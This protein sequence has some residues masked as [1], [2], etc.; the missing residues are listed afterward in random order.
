MNWGPGRDSTDRETA[1]VAE[2]HIE[3][4]ILTLDHGANESP[5]AC[6]L[7][8]ELVSLGAGIVDLAAGITIIIA[9]LDNL[10]HRLW[11]SKLTLWV[12]VLFLLRLV[13]YETRVDLPLT[14]NIPQ[15]MSGHFD[16][17]WK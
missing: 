6:S 7:G 2:R 16:F 11:C 15:D 8:V 4:L 9:D 10:T 13:R 12:T 14:Y 1:L 5:C 17:G 3:T